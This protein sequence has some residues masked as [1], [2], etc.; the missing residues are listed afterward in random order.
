MVSIY[1]TTDLIFLS[2]VQSAARSA[3][4]ELLTVASEAALRESATDNDVRQVILDLTAPGCE[5]A[6]LVPAIR[7][8]AASAHIVAYAPHVMKARLAAAQAAGCDQVLTRGQ[9]DS[10][11]V[12]V[13]QSTLDS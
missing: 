12:D 2:R 6:A 13:L 9:F 4:V 1:L 11:L 3:G 8:A 5:P 10:R 7:E